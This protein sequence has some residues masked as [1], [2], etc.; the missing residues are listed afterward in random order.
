MISACAGGGGGP[1]EAPPPQREPL[2]PISDLMRR[3]NAS[4]TVECLEEVIARLQCGTG[5]F[6]NANC[7]GF[8]EKLSTLIATS[9]GLPSRPATQSW[10]FDWEPS[11]FTI[12]ADAKGKLTEAV[13]P[14]GSVT[15]TVETSSWGNGWI[16]GS[17]YSADLWNHENSY[18]AEIA[19]DVDG[20]LQYVRGLS[21]FLSEQRIAYDGLSAIGHPE[22]D[23]VGTPPVELSWHRYSSSGFVAFQASEIALIANPYSAG[24]AYQSFGAW[25]YSNVSVTSKSFGS[26]TPAIAVP[27]SGTATFSGTFGGFY[28][29]PE[30]LGSLA[31][32]D[33]SVTADFG[34]RSLAFA[35][36][37]TT[38]TR[39]LQTSSAA[40][41][42]NLTGSLTYAPGAGTFTGTLVSAG[43]TMAGPTNGRFYGPAAQELGGVFVVKAADGPESLTGAYG[44]KR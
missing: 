10:G 39:D 9:F 3:C 5:W 33:V 7:L 43:G 35:T 41:G 19:Y 14:G 1:S 22:I 28:T 17:H 37:N 26:A 21:G 2:V 13:G 32:A 25:S 38:I 18:A 24:W 20:K 8:E 11:P 29:S 34:A 31:A 30:G 42:L 27:S 16:T 4:P 6:E 40:P 12:W 44:A 36:S 15:Y 23:L